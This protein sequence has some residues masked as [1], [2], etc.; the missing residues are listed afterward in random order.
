MTA[1]LRAATRPLPRALHPGAWW[2]WALG[3]AAAASRT[4]NPVLLALV[5]AVAGLVVVRRRTDA[6]WAL[7]FRMYL[8]FGAVIVVM[9][10]VFR[11]VFGGGGGETVLVT[12]PEIPLP[13][14]AAGIR[15]LGPVAAEEVLGGFYAGLQLAAMVVCVGAANALANPK[16]MLKAMPGALYEVG[17]SV[18]VALTVAPQ[19]V[20]SVHRVRRARRLRGAREKGR[21]ALRGIVIPVL[22]DALNRSLAL[23]AAMA[24]RGYGRTGTVAGKARLAVG[25]LV[26]GGL[27][28][29]A[30]G[31]YGLLDSS[32][33]RYL[34][35]PLLLT[36]VAAG[37]AGFALGGRRVRRSGYRPDRWRAGELLTAA[38]GLAAAAL[39]YLSTRVDPADLYP[40]L[41]PLAWPEVSPLPLLAVLTGLLPAVLSPPPPLAPSAS[42][43]QL[44]GA[45]A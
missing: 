36:G 41:T 8:L 16:R 27:L 14:A 12:L 29:I 10:V 13:E 22:E 23:A 3:L 7:S 4:T 11:V 40:S 31:L 25:I 32:A 2:L 33:P 5:L 35:L 30:A 44:Q 37:V 1:V 17:T 20:E 39:M 6:P 19:L 15:L 45:S 43:P 34:G 26:L 9:R 18:V 38:S 28:G 24:S 21:G 42:V